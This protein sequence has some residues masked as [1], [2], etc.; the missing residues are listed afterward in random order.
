MIKPN[1]RGF[2]LIEILIALVILAVVGALM[3]TGLRGAINTQRSIT[4]KATRLGDVQ[5]AIAILERDLIQYIDRPILIASGMRMPSFQVSY[6]NNRLALE[7]THGGW[8]NPQNAPR[9]ALQRVRYAF[10]G[11][12]ITRSIWPVLDRTANTPV[13]T[14]PFLNGVTHFSIRVLDQNKQW[15]KPAETG[16]QTILS[17]VPLAVE[18]NLVVTGFGHITRV[19]PLSG[20]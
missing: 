11:E 3:V 8:S 19:I 2:T 9:S 17:N 4:Q 5:M 7:F 18:V 10:D 6:P 13:Y 16:P 14:E 1:S 12:K 20:T 15:S